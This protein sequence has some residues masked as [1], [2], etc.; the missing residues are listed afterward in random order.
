MGTLMMPIRA[1]ATMTTG[2]WKTS[3]N[4]RKSKRMRLRVGSM[5]KVASATPVVIATSAPMTRWATKK[6][7]NAKPDAASSSEGPMYA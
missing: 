5:P 4:A 2:V 3:A 6:W 7:Q 1:S